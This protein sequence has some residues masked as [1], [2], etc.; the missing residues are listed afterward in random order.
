MRRHGII[1]ILWSSHLIIIPNKVHLKL[2]EERGGVLAL[3]LPS[4][5]VYRQS[6]TPH[7]RTPF[8]VA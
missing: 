3:K 6:H 1:E 4:Q 2:L 5:F 8:A 7:G